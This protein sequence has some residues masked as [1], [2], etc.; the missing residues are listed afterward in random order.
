VDVDDVVVVVVGSLLVVVE[1]VVSSVVGG[2]SAKA[3]ATP[4][5]KRI[6]APTP[7]MSSLSGMERIIFADRE[8]YF[9]SAASRRTTHRGHAA[10][11]LRHAVPEDASAIGAVFDAA[12]RTAWSYLGDLVAEPM[13]TPEDWSGLWPTS[14]RRM[15]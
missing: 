14:R 10:I 4:T 1:V 5:E 6:T 11:T 15:R 9:R 12:V 8:P 13:F 7:A 2:E 3:A